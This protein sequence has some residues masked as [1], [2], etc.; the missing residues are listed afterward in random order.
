MSRNDRTGIC[1]GCMGEIGESGECSCGWRY[2]YNEEERETFL[3]PGTLLDKGQ[4]LIGKTIGRGGFG[5]TYLGRKQDE[6]GLKVAIKEYFPKRLAGR[7]TSR[8]DSLYLLDRTDMDRNNLQERYEKGKAGFI[9]EAR[10][11]AQLNELPSIVGVLGYFEEN[12]TAYI[13]M[14]YVDGIDLQHY[15]REMGRTLTVEEVKKFIIP[16]ADDLYKVHEAGIIHRDISPDN[17][18]ITRNG[19]VKLIDFGASVLQGE[20]ARV[21][22]KS[23]FAPPEQYDHERE[24]LGPWTDVY[25]L[26]ATIYMLLS[27]IVLQDA[28]DRQHTDMYRTLNNMGIKVPGKL[29]RL[30]KRGLNPDW[31]KRCSSVRELAAGLKKVPCDRRFQGWAGAGVLFAVSMAICLGG[32][33]YFDQRERTERQIP[34]ESAAV[35][36][37]KES[38]LMTKADHAESAADYALYGDMVYIRYLFDDGTIMLMRS[39]VGTDDFERVEYLTDGRFGQF[40]VYDAYLYLSGIDDHCIYRVSLERLTKLE[41]Q[42]RPMEKLL[43]AGFLERISGPLANEKYGFHIEEGFLYALTEEKGG[44]ECKR[45]TLDGKEQYTTEL[46]LNLTNCVFWKG[47]LI[48]TVRETEETVLYRMRLD[49]CYYEKLARYEGEIAAMR[50]S[51]ETLYYLLNGTEESYLGCIDINGTE[52]KELVRKN[53][54]D[55][56]YCDMTGIVDQNN[57]YYTCSTKDSQLLNHLYCYSLEDGNNRQISSECGRYIA[58]SD[59]I[60]YIIFASMDGSEIRQMNKDGS[61]PRVMREADGGTGILDLV[62]ITSLAIIRD[63]VYYLDGENV[64]YKKIESEEL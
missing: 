53:N 49:G 17:I 58:T 27:G 37:I 28:L 63:H 60:H 43:E 40:C 19:R 55:L 41:D 29:D 59:E 46:S 62:D 16:I 4:Y 54:E 39:P 34:T 25:A 26:C 15:M 48:F 56:Q 47:F 10:R 44:Y 22:K 31:E 13:V 23:G 57:I 9:E 6:L 32:Y 33:L 51:G 21:L 35:S 64:A 61:N 3:P 38:E 42:D 18:M 1:Y 20:N 2:A 8:S 12:H 24:N 14:E 7:R 30:L 52:R 50:I 36:R 11:L 45:M 5:I